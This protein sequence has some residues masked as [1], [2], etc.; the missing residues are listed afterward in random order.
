MAAKARRDVEQVM[1]VQGK[2]MSSLTQN[3]INNLQ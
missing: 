1:K 2:W 3:W